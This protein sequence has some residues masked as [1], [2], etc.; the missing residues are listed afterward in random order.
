MLEG[1][2]KI[3]NNIKVWI[4]HF[5]NCIQILSFK[6]LQSCQRAAAIFFNYLFLLFHFFSPI[7]VWACPS[8]IFYGEYSSRLAFLGGILGVRGG[9]DRRGWRA[10]R[11]LPLASLDMIL[12]LQSPW[13]LI[14]LISPLRQFLINF[15]SGEISWMR[16]GVRSLLR[17]V[18]STLLDRGMKRSIWR[19]LCSSPRYCQSGCGGLLRTLSI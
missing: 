4:V 2:L 16:I 17:L 14:P 10:R 9:R 5:N 18:D 15:R 1:F 12:W 11:S 13:D 7:F 19:G 6:F 8:R 3:C